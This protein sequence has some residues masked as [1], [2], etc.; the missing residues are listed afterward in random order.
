[1]TSKKQ[2]WWDISTFIAIL[3][4][5]SGYVALSIILSPIFPKSQ[6]NWEVRAWR[7]EASLNFPDYN[8]RIK[9]CES[10]FG[11]NLTSFPNCVNQSKFVYTY[12]V[13]T[14]EGK[15][16]KEEI[17]SVSSE[18]TILIFHPDGSM[19]ANVNCMIREEAEKYIL[20]RVDDEDVVDI[21]LDYQKWGCK[22]KF[23]NSTKT[24]CSACRDFNTKKEVACP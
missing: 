8:A 5:L 23:I 21:K 9:F 15:D 19:S 6:E 20:E 14:I 12:Q 11:D 22:D 10:I 2:S 17:K 16:C 7:N 1:M 18:Y 3:L 13:P 24:T 4:I